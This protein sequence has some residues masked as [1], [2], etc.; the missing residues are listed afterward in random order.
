MKSPFNSSQTLAAVGIMAALMAGAFA[1]GRTQP[2]AD[3]VLAAESSHKQSSKPEATM[4][5]AEKAS[6]PVLC[7]ECGRVML[8]RSEERQGKASGL[9]AIGGAVVGGLLG[10]QLGGG[11]GKKIATVGGAVA[12]GM[13]GNEIEKRNKARRIWIVRVAH[14]D[15]STQNY[16]QGSDPGLRAGDV[17]IVRDGQVQRR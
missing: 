14:K 11:T 4:P 8:V 13:A 15:G 10:H 6:E 16:E 12:G 5:A 7:E 9:G 1:L 3:P 2:A 17:V